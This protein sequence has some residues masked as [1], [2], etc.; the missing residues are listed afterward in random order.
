[1]SRDD[2]K[3]RRY[4]DEEL[5]LI[6]RKASELQ[7][8]PRGRGSRVSAGGF[9]LEEIQSIALE[10]GIDPGAVTR[11]VALLGIL[12][13]EGKRG[14]AATIFG[15]PDKFHMDSEIPGCL[16]SEGMGRILEEI[17]RTAEHQGKVTEVL[18]GVEWQTVGELSAINV[19]ITPA[20]DRT[21]I[22][23]V[24]NRGAAAGATFIL[25]LVGAAVLGGVLGAITTPESA[26]GIVGVVGGTL[27]A[28]FL[29]ARTLWVRGTKKFRRRLVRLMDRL[30]Q[31]V[32]AAALPPEPGE[33][34]SD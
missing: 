15:G 29:T 5:A 20:G 26:A 18:G 27:G 25:P 1:M 24:G 19:N 33:G 3:K 34:E 10:A 8:T 22:Q 13:Q 32:E 7:E 12:E 6:L 16:P 28:W 9:L 17:R 31:S 21:S 14:L 23:I 2:S 4:S 30:S 11:A